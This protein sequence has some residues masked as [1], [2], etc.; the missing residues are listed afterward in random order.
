VNIDA[1]AYSTISQACVGFAKDNHSKLIF[2]TTTDHH[3]G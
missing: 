1:R 2:K 3:A